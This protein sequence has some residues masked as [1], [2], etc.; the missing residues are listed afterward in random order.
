MK[1]ARLNRAANSHVGTHSSTFILLA[2]VVFLSASQFLDIRNDDAYITYRY[3]QN[4]V[5]GRGFVFNPGERVLAT[6]SP[7]HALMMSAV[8]LVYPNLPLAGVLL[9]C[10]A[11]LSLSMHVYLILELF[12][13]RKAGL[14]SALLVILNIHTYSVF[15]LET[16][17]LLSLEAALIYY[18]LRQRLFIA[19]V[20]GASAVLTRL[21]AVTLVLA[22]AIHYLLTG[23]HIR[24]LLVPCTTFLAIVLSWFAFSLIYYGSLFPSTAFAK[25]GFADHGNVFIQAMWPKVLSTSLANNPYLSAIPIVFAFVGLWSALRMR[26]WDLLV[27]YLWIVIYTIGYSLLNIGFPHSWYYYPLVVA[28]LM[29]GCQGGNYLID[30]LRKRLIPR[31]FYIVH[32]TATLL[33]VILIAIQIGTVYDYSLT[34]HQSPWTTARERAYIE[35]SDWLR[36][37]TDEHATVAALEIG[38]LGYYSNRSIVDLLGLATPAAISNVKIGDSGRTITELSPDYV[39]VQN[40]A[41][42]NTLDVPGSEALVFLGRSFAN[43]RSVERFTTE[44]Y[45]VTVYQ[46]VD[47]VSQ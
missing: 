16:V 2:V 6:T 26:N 15:P 7:L 24:R 23:R 8:A 1:T 5:Q 27:V 22:L 14:I 35:V 17:I 29:L 38:T 42:E 25:T 39:V 43:Y 45:D 3:A 40:R 4:L 19:A 21:D 20:L 9:S 36:K 46:R 32:V 11:L 13:Y 18:Y 34:H 44:R 37:N 33:V 31:H 30:A 10:I 47:N 28:T 41:G 12:G